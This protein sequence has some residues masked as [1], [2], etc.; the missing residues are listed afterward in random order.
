M[1]NTKIDFIN[2]ENSVPVTLRFPAWLVAELDKL[3][4]GSKST[5]I[6]IA[7]I[8]KLNRVKIDAQEAA[9]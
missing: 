4:K 9:Q 8:E 5:F 6:R 7:I 1:S 2:N 3:P